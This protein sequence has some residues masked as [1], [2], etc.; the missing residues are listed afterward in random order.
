M[1]SLY[2]CDAV[3]N[4]FHADKAGPVFI[5]G[6]DKTRELMEKGDDWSNVE[7]S[8]RSRYAILSAEHVGSKRKCN[9]TFGTG[10]AVKNTEIINSFFVA[11]PV[12]KQK[13]ISYFEMAF[14]TIS[15]HN[16][17]L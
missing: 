17:A 3:D 7:C 16:C 6:L 9:F 4:S 13:S 10:V 2:F 15:H 14:G 5:D 11:Q 1:R 12:G 8:E